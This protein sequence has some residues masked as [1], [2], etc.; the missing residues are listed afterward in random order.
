MPKTQVKINLKSHVW[1]LVLLFS[2]LGMFVYTVGSTWAE[3]YGN[4]CQGEFCGFGQGLLA[5]WGGLLLTLGLTIYALRKYVIRRLLPAVVCAICVLGLGLSSPLA[6]FIQNPAKEASAVKVAWVSGVSIWITFIAALIALL[7]LLKTFKPAGLKFY[8]GVI[9]G[10]VI[11]V[12][13]FYR[14]DN[15]YSTSQITKSHLTTARQSGIDPYLPSYSLPDYT[16]ATAYVASGA[17]SYIET[18]YDKSTATELSY[19]IDEYKATAPLTS[20]NCQKYNPNPN[21]TD[22]HWTTCV[23]LGT[24]HD[25]PIYY[26]EYVSD[27]SSYNP[28]TYNAYFM[29]AGST[30]ISLTDF[31]GGN[32]L[33]KPA[34]LPIIQSLHR[35][36]DSQIARFMP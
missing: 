12:S 30:V 19:Y 5:V 8:S 33:T 15:S 23:Q 1:L 18:R 7:V 36:T 26:S 16:L 13:V 24:F 28:A 32:I 35:V 25:N 4:T 9:I 17:P 20:A 3:Q 21:V 11:V 2:S 22:A 14:I 29:Q 10:T 31:A 34:A 6:E 27:P